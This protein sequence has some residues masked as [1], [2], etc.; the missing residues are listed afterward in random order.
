[1]PVNSKAF[2]FNIITDGDLNGITPVGLDSRTGELSVDK[3]NP[4]FITI[5]RNCATA[6]TKI[7]S[8]NDTSVW[9]II[10]VV[11]RGIQGA[12]RVSIWSRVVREE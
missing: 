6:D 3:N 4:E 5:W 12:P 8:P 9:I 10:I 1:M 11:S 7:I 2:I